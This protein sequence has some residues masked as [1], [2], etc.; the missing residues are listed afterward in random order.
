MSAPEPQPHGIYWRARSLRRWT[1]PPPSSMPSPSRSRT[2]D[3][4]HPVF[5]LDE[6]H[7]IHQDTLDHLHILLNYAW[8]SKP[9]LLLVFVGLSDLD[10]RLRLR[11]NRSLYSRL[12]RRVAIDPLAPE[13]AAD[14]VPLRLERAAGSHEGHE[15]RPAIDPP[16]RL[17]PRGA[18]GQAVGAKTRNSVLTVVAGVLKLGQ[19]FGHIATVRRIRLVRVKP[20]EMSRG[21]GHRLGVPVRPSPPCGRVDAGAVLWPA[22]QLVSGSVSPMRQKVEYLGGAMGVHAREDV[23]DVIEGIDVVRTPPTRE[24]V[25]AW[26]H[27][28]SCA[29]AGDS[30]GDES[31]GKVK[32][33]DRDVRALG[34]ALSS[35]EAG[36]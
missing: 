18:G 26:R 19:E 1:P 10:D 31:G 34:T 20:A 7:L 23:G 8:D 12:H 30:I 21:R 16:R 15:A 2:K 35:G 6:A 29:N 17:G 5:L 24:G 22:V 13:A 14:Y 28:R 27:P 4:L 11:P 36:P 32:R 9:L 25:R 3:R 33:R